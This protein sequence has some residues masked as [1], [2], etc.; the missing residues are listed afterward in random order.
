M[1]EKEIIKKN[2]QETI[3]QTLHLKKQPPRYTYKDKKDNPRI[4]ESET[5]PRPK[6]QRQQKRAR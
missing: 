4:H 6:K 3:P 2:E 1:N 5:E